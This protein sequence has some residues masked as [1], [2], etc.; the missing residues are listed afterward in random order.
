MAP[1]SPE[2]IGQ[3][4][5]NVM[6]GG[7]GATTSVRLDTAGRNRF[8]ATLA[9]SA[10][11]FAADAPKMPD[12]MYLALENITS[13]ADAGMFYVY[14]NLPKDADPSQHP[15]NLVGTVSLFGASKASD[16]AGPHAGNGL[17]ET[18][19]ITD[20]VDALHIDGKMDAEH[21]DVRL[22]PRT[23]LPEEESISI[24]KINI[25]RQGS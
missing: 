2:L 20:L 14:V 19:D 1:S 5:G 17:T 7:N 11:T 13:P 16:P 3:N 9:P 15:Q 8:S 6:L 24:G 21:L 12:R 22:V 10:T 23:S 25:Y 4:S 18:F